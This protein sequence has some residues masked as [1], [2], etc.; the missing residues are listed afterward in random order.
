MALFE[1]Y[2]DGKIIAQ[3]DNEKCIPPLDVLLHMKD[4]GYTFRMNGKK[5]VPKKVQN[6]G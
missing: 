1:A 5:Y 4:H 3:T 6:N 2:R